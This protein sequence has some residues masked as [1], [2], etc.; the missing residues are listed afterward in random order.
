MTQNE[1]LRRI[2]HVLIGVAAYLVPVIGVKAALILA[3]VAIPANMWLLPRLPLLKG[4]IRSDGSGTRAIW[5][6]PFSCA[7]LLGVFYEQPRYAQAGWL[8]LGIGDGLAPFI[9]MAVKGPLWPWNARKRIL[10][11]AASG[12]VAGLAALPVVPAPAAIAVAVVG[13]LADSLPLE[14]NLTWPLLTGVA[15]WVCDTMF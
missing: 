4:V 11:S 9:A 14:D 5:L 10:V 6:Y 8:A 13:A 3:I 12:L 7:L 15:A 2:V 1:I